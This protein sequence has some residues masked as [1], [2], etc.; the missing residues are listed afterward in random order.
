M[1]CDKCGVDITNETLVEVSCDRYG[2]VEFDPMSNG[3]V[4]CDKCG[5]SFWKCVK[6]NFLK[7]TD[8]Y[9]NMVANLKWDEDDGWVGYLSRKDDEE[10]YDLHALDS[11]IQ[12][13]SFDEDESESLVRWIEATYPSYMRSTITIPF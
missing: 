8:R 5:A 10:E 3:L 9:K 4:L 7:E 11:E 13:S 6:E 2:K 1:K 12:L